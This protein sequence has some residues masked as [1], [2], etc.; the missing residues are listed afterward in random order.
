MLETLT[1][2]L[3][4]M[5]N[6]IFVSLCIVLFAPL[7]V[8]AATFHSADN[9]RITDIQ[10]ENVYATAQ[11]IE[12]DARLDGDG[13]FATQTLIINEPVAGDLF[14]A[15]QSIVINAPITGDVRGFAQNIDI[16]AD[17]GGELLAAA[18]FLSVHESVTVGGDLM[19]AGD[20]LTLSGT[21]NADVKSSAAAIT[22]GENATIAG[23]ADFYNTPSEN[24]LVQSDAISEKMQIH[25]IDDDRAQNASRNSFLGLLSSFLV[26]LFFAI[27][28]PLLI[29]ALLRKHVSKILPHGGTHYA[30][31]A[32]I[33]ALTLFALPAIIVFCMITLLGIPLGVFIL[34]LSIVLFLFALPFASILM[35]VV[36]VNFYHHKTST[37]RK[38]HDVDYVHALVGGVAMMAVSLIPLIGWIVGFFFTCAAFGILVS[39]LLTL[40]RKSTP[41]SHQEQL[42]I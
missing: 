27:L 5:K 12:V 34:F 16:R 41:S 40:L 26:A 35:G 15:G 29:I 18:Q 10:E 31:K 22:I 37:P 30:K 1:D 7:G 8:L 19:S 25:A 6:Y 14:V 24:L 9:L 38:Q 39:A 28:Y 21:V 2:K 42:D 3:I 11:N 4:S 13:F 32:G 17:I 20:K 23:T 33:G 36:L